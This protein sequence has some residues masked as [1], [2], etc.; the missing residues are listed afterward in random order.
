MKIV[1]RVITVMLLPFFVLYPVDKTPISDS[2]RF[3]KMSKS[4]NILLL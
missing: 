4:V 1:E 2:K 3:E